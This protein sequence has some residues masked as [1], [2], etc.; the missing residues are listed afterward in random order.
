LLLAV[1]TPRYFQSQFAI[2]EWKTFE[3]REKQSNS[4]LIVPMMVMDPGSGA[5]SWFMTRQS[6]DARG[7]FIDR[8]STSSVQTERAILHLAEDISSKLSMKPVFTDTPIVSPEDISI[9]PP[10]PIAIPRF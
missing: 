6:F 7:M 9:E 4:M 2:A 3:G 8:A 1:V 5:P 10:P